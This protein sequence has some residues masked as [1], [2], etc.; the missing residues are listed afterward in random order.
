LSI[1]QTFFEQFF[2]TK[3]FSTAFSLLTIWLY[4]FWQK[5]IGA[6]AAHKMFVKL[7]TLVNFTNFFGAA[8]FLQKC[9]LYLYFGIVTFW[10][11]N[12]RAKRSVKSS[13]I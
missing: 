3:V 2:Q 9:F 7:I 10:Q 8:F 4:I 6:K 13:V 1:S 11:K 5:N 12:I